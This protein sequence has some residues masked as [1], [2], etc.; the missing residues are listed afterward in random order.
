MSIGAFSALNERGAQS[1][2]DEDNK[3][4]TEVST[5]IRFDAVYASIAADATIEGLMD[6]KEINSSGFKCVMDDPDPSA[7]FVPY[8]AFG[9]GGA[10]PVIPDLVP[11]HTRR[12]HFTP[13]A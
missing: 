9:P 4:T 5:A 6:V 12:L 10:P 1:F 7:K 11:I 8:I 13:T 3:D 2:W